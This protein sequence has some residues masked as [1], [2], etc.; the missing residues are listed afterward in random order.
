MAKDKKK[1]A[2]LIISVKNPITDDDRPQALRVF[3]DEQMLE[4]RTA[5]VEDTLCTCARLDGVD[6]KISV[7]PR[8]RV[9]MVERAIANLQHRH[10]G[11]PAIS[12]LGRRLEILVQELA[13]LGERIRDAVEHELA[14]GYQR[15]LV[16]GGYNP[17]ITGTLLKTA[18]KEMNKHSIILGPTIRGSFYLVGVDAVHPGLFDDVPVGTDDAYAVIARRL[19]EAHLAWKELDL[20]YDISHQEDIEFIIRDINQFRLTGN[21]YSARATEEVLTRYLEPG[22]EQPI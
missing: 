16:I 19:H 8:E 3:T 14:A 7:A 10:P 6:L 18:L 20:W 13:P 1:T 11:E 5:F 17:T 22:K 12:S 15:V 21:E 9:K 2:A 4:L